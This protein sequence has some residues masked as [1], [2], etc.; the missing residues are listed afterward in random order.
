MIEDDPAREPPGVAGARQIPHIGL[1]VQ[2]LEEVLQ[3]GQD[4]QHPVDEAHHLLQPPD[5]HGGEAHEGDDL[6]DGGEAPQM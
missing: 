2:H 6:A 3:L 1:G 5:E 4:Q